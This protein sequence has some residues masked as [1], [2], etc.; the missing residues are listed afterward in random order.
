M[1]LGFWWIFHEFQ[2]NTFWF[3]VCSQ[4]AISK[5][6]S[7]LQKGFSSLHVAR[8]CNA[9]TLQ[10]EWISCTLQGW[11]TVS[12][13]WLLNGPEKMLKR[14]CKCV[15]CSW[16]AQSVAT[17]CDSVIIRLI[18]AAVHSDYLPGLPTPTPIS[19][20]WPLWWASCTWS[21]SIWP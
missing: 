15:T 2:G 16:A 17:R 3:D 12:K 14:L 19:W 1:Y 11:T 6:A 9:S 8:D 20:L 7:W 10:K 5:S 18:I 21:L 13:A 4:M